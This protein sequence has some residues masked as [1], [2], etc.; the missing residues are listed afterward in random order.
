MG[1]VLSRIEADSRAWADDDAT[2]VCVEMPMGALSEEENLR[3]ALLEV[4]GRCWPELDEAPLIDSR[5]HR[6]WVPLKTPGFAAR[7]S[8]VAT[9]PGLQLAGEHLPVEAGAF[10]AE[11]A[12]R[13]GRVAA[14]RALEAMR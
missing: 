12:A 7:E 14:A 11:A 3:E 2:V 10:G 13:S 9:V 5:V 1:T 4:V 8:V 6:W